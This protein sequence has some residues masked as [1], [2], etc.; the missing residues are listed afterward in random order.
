MDAGVLSHIRERSQEI[1]SRKKII[2]FLPRPIWA[3][4]AAIV[5][6]TALWSVHLFDQPSVTIT[7]GKHD[8]DK[9]GTI[10]IVDA[11]M[12]AQALK[13]GQSLPPEWDVSEDGVLNEQDRVIGADGRL[14]QAFGVI[15]RTRGNHFQTR[16]MGKNCIGG[17]R[18]GC[19]QLASAATP[20]TTIRPPIT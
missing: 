17:L 2:P 18:V 3:A 1:K 19:A 9:N 16:E 11:Y 8:I 10:D 14:E 5:L 6:C 12:L 20:T 15:R 4:A 7:A 13:T